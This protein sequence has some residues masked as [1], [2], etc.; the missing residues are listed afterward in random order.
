MVSLS[1]KLSD[2]AG[3]KSKSSLSQEVY[4]EILTRLMDNRLVPGNMLNRRDV[5]KELGVS[6][7]PVLEA[8][9]Q[10]E[11]EG[12]L[13]S[14]PRKGSFVKPI[15][16]EDVYGQLIVREALECEGARMYC[17]KPVR[18]NWSALIKA[19]EDADNAS[20]GSVTQWEAEIHFHLTLLDLAGCVPLSQAF[21]RTIRL[22]LFYQMN[23]IFLPENQ[24]EY[25]HLDLIDDLGKASPDA[26]ERTVRRHI[27]SGKHPF[28][29]TGQVPVH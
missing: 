9:L 26:A 20:Y 22:G 10:L 5:A 27:R 29:I 7:A 6:V 11:I 19:A 4:H 3:K 14:V 28:S 15:K 12:F 13:E 18:D 2:T 1:L 17:G 16:R 24:V 23:H 25:K 8:M 21:I